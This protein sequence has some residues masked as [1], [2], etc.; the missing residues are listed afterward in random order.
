[1]EIR[2]LKDY[3]RAVRN[4]DEAVQTAKSDLEIDGA[5]KRFELAYE[6]AWKL[7]KE[8]LSFLGITCTSPRLC[9]KYAYQNGLIEDEVTWLEM[10]DVRNALVHEYSY[11]YFAHV[12]DRF[13]PQMLALLERVE[14]SLD[15]L[16]EER[17]E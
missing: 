2:H 11:E 8:Y 5:L 16:E 6:L 15:S 4:L 10:I 17:H 14:K 13:V 3:R 9:F 7:I 1:M 12:R